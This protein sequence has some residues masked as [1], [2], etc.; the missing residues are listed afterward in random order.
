[1]TREFLLIPKIKYES[2]LKSL[3]AINDRSSDDKNPSVESAGHMHEQQ[4]QHQMQEQQQHQQTQDTNQS[5]GQVKTE[6]HT[7]L[8][9][10]E[11]ADKS[12]GG[13]GTMKK[14]AKI[15]RKLHVKRTVAE[16]ES[17]FDKSSEHTESKNPKKV[18]WVNY[19]V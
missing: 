16:M 8:P 19:V 10:T 17:I 9:K 12:S 6:E 5:G 4:E 1:M 2:M 13:N 18:K 3:N 7:S 14:H 11:N 15:P